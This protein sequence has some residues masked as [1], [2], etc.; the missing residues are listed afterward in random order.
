MKRH[1]EWE[2][3]RAATTQ[4][5]NKVFA[6]LKWLVLSVILVGLYPNRLGV[7]ILSAQMFIMIAGYIYASCALRYID[8]QIR[9]DS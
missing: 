2:S 7:I 1:G 9:G 5:L 3:A 4:M 8:R 6:N